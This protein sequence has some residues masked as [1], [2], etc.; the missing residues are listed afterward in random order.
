MR[1]GSPVPLPKGMTGELMRQV[2]ALD[3][4][5]M[6]CEQVRLSC[7]VARVRLKPTNSTKNMW[8]RAHVIHVADCKRRNGFGSD[9]AT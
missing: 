1:Q 5:R 2:A 8:L 9:V 4:T 3:V 6:S 7:S